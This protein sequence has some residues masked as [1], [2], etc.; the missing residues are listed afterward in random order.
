[1]TPT[2]PSGMSSSPLTLSQ[3]KITFLSNFSYEI[4]A[5]ESN[6]LR[7]PLTVFGL[8]IWQSFSP[9]N[10]LKSLSI[11]FTNIETAKNKDPLIISSTNRF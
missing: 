2:T 3:I 4:E 6:F 5:K 10:C 11:F 9:I 8:I 7:T 1:M